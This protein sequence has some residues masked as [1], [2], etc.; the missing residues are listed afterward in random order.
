MKLGEKEIKLGFLKVA[1]WGLR[2]WLHRLNIYGTTGSKGTTFLL[3]LQVL[4]YLIHGG[5]KH[6]LHT[7][8]LHYVF[9]KHFFLRWRDNQKVHAIPEPSVINT[10]LVLMD[11]FPVIL[12]ETFF[13]RKRRRK[14]AVARLF[15]A[16]SCG[17]ISSANLQWT[18]SKLGAWRT[19]GRPT[20]PPDQN[21]QIFQ[22]RARCETVKLG[23]SCRNQDF[24]GKKS[25]IFV[26]CAVLW[27]L[28]G[29]WI[30]KQVA[31]WPLYQ[32][33]KKIWKFHL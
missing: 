21:Q 24:W 6:F 11:F 19:W 13:T 8:L 10:L 25:Q 26:N 5:M 1:L 17:V 4:A 15:P 2:I 12:A 3:G 16:F 20:C 9:C 29:W 30:L 28:A 33:V 14:R 27:W 7:R 23:G 31:L 18:A 32:K 22:G